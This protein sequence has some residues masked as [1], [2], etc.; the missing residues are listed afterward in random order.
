MIILR[1]CHNFQG[2][3]LFKYPLKPGADLGFSRGGGGGGGGGGGVDLKKKSKI[4]STLFS[5]A[6]ELS[7]ITIKT[8]F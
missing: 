4:W 5:R 3:S 8:P 6:S 7:Q 1:N 2:V